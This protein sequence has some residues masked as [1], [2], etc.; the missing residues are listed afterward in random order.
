MREVLAWEEVSLETAKPPRIGF[1]HDG[2][3]LITGGLGGLGL[4]FANEI[5]TRTSAARV[6]LTGRSELSL[7]KQRRMD[8]L[9]GEGGR[10]L[11][12][13]VDLGDLASV[14]R[15]VS[16]IQEEYGRLD[17]ILHSAGM[18]AD[19]FI[20]KK[21]ASEFRE[22]L[23]PK[24]EGTYH[25]DQAT[26]DIEL[27]FF[28]L[29]SS[30]AGAMGNVGQ[31]DYA[32]ANAFMDHFAA[33]RN[34]LVAAKTRR[35]QTRS[36][37]WTLVASRGY[38]RRSGEP[39]SDMAQC[40]T[41]ADANTKSAWRRFIAAWNSLDDQLLVNGLEVWTKIRSAL[42]AVRTGLCWNI[43]WL[44]R[45]PIQDI[46]QHGLVVKTQDYLLPAVLG[47]VLKLPVP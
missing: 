21:S 27:D 4:V 10:V 36:I 37:N 28:V 46:P 15:L 47:W 45:R 42:L 20:V 33:Y 6:V 24:V 35:G 26:R 2:V 16:F 5:L 23:A 9:P 18:I 31:A 39:G 44:F 7:E 43:R 32:T 41:A 11:Y 34:S 38:E 30:V 3:Y 19:N 40:R 17:G 1:K 12:R 22:V 29:F 13:Q 8:A 14:Q 25:L